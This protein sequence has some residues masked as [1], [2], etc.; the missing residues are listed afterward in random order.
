MKS[1]A[2]K[3]EIQSRGLKLKYFADLAGVSLPLLSMYLNGVRNM[4]KE[5]EQKILEQLAK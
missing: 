4:P 1:L 5:V 3:Q 2:L